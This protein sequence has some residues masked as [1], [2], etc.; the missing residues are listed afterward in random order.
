VNLFGGARYTVV[1]GSVA[2]LALLGACADFD[3][4]S[5]PTAP[6]ELVATPSFV[7][8]IQPIFT[9][10][11][12]TA[13][14]HNVV[15]HQRQLTLAAGHAYGQLVGVRSVLA[16]QYERV[17]PGDVQRSWLYRMIAADPALRPGFQR[18]P[19]GRT[20][21]TDNQIATIANWIAQGA[22]PE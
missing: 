14:C 16:P 21:L 15:T 3:P 19:L 12:A 4:T 9:A 20:P 5:P 22:R 11:C 18:M 8:D 17:T 2:A 1:C 7:R 10:R 6:D 13:S